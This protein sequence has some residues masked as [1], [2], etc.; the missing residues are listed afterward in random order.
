M[1]KKSVYYN[2][3]VKAKK[4]GDQEQMDY[5]QEQMDIWASPEEKA[6]RRRQKMAQ[7]PRNRP[8]G[9]YHVKEGDNFFSIAGDIYGDQRMVGE[10]LRANPGFQ[11]VSPG[12]V[13][14]LPELPE[15]TPLITNEEWGD[16]L[17]TQEGVAQAGGNPSGKRLKDYS[18]KELKKYYSDLD[19]YRKAMDLRAASMGQEYH[20]PT[21][22]ERLN[23][24]QMEMPGLSS[25][26]SDNAISAEEAAVWQRAQDQFVDWVVNFVKDEG[27][28]LPEKG[29]ENTPPSGAEQALTIDEGL[30]DVV[31]KAEE[32]TE[33]L[34]GNE[35]AIIAEEIDAGGLD[36][37]GDNKT[38]IDG[39]TRVELEEKAKKANEYLS[40][41]AMRDWEV[42]ENLS[43]RDNDEFEVIHYTD[44]LKYLKMPPESSPGKKVN[45]NPFVNGLAQGF[46]DTATGLTFAE[47]LLI[48]DGIPFDEEVANVTGYLYSLEA[49]IL[50]GESYWGKPHGDLPEM[51]VLSQDMS[52]STLELAASS[53]KIAGGAIG[54][55]VGSV[56]PGFGTALGFET[57]YNIGIPLDVAT[58]SLELVYEVLEKTGTIPN[59]INIGFTFENNQLTIYILNYKH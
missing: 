51:F 17:E 54:G 26:T 45:T 5:W 27:F 8:G 44:V 29:E 9:L 3:W 34:E 55:F 57:G 30:V 41:E 39:P 23:I 18:E 4:R 31:P 49:S 7:A 12:M 50:K 33:P 19:D 22:W 40:P 15:E 43:I 6:R 35:R 58:T 32:E 47:L 25:P 24:D 21:E 36:V 42:I 11:W 13:L 10:L 20:T 1:N 53:P 28:V 59:N 37:A 14:H 16:L 2:E 56:I 52:I 46:E 38:G 48:L